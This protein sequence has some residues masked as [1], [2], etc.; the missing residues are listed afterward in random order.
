MNVIDYADL[1]APKLLETFSIP[2]TGTGTRTISNRGLLVVACRCPVA[3]CNFEQ[4]DMLFRLRN[5]GLRIKGSPIRVRSLILSWYFSK[6]PSD[7]EVCKGVVAIGM[8]GENGKLDLGKVCQGCM[9]L[10]VLMQQNDASL[11]SHIQ[12]LS[13]HVHIYDCSFDDVRFGAAFPL[14]HS[15]CF[16]VS[17]HHERLAL[18]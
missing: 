16:I 3:P 7:I 5:Q 17:D 13:A 9:L 10:P 2:A 15:T 1:A 14:L 18:A 11:C 12:T 4:M 8:E 6:F